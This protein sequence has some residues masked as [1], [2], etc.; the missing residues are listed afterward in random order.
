MRQTAAALEQLR[1]TAAGQQTAVARAE[2][3]LTQAQDTLAARQ[4][5]KASWDALLAEKDRIMADFAQWREADARAQ[6]Q[7]ELA[8]QHNQLLGQMKPLEI[9]ISRAQSGLEAERK[10]LL[11]RAAQ[12]VLAQEEREELT[13]QLGALETKQADLQEESLRLAALEEALSAARARLQQTLGERALREKEL[14]GLQAQARQMDKVAADKA[15]LQKSQEEAALLIHELEE[16]VEVIGAQRTHVAQLKAEREALGN[17]QPLL[18]AKMKELRKRLDELSAAGSDGVCPV[19]GQS[20]SHEHLEDALEN[21]RQ[22]GTAFGDLY[23]DNQKRLSALEVELPQV[24]KTMAQGERLEG[25]LQQ[26]QKVVTQTAARLEELARQEAAWSDGGLEQL[27]DAAAVLA[28]KSTLEAQTAEVEALTRAAANKQ[29]V[30][31]ALRAAQ[32]AHAEAKARLGEL[33]RLMRAWA[34]EGEARLTGVSD[35][36][37]SGAFAEDEKQQLVALQKR[38]DAVGYDH[39]THQAALAAREVLSAAPERQQTLQRAEAALESLQTTLV[40][41]SQQIT[42]QEA[43]LADQ[44]REQAENEAQIA[45]LAENSA[46]LPDLETEVFQLREEEIAATG[47]VGRAQQSVAVLNTLRLQRD[48]LQTEKEQLALRVRRLKVLETSCGRKGVQALLIEQALPEIEDRAN[49]LLERLT[50][51]DMRVRFDTQRQKKSGDAMLETLDIVIEDRSG[52]RPYENYSGG[53]Q[54][55]INFAIRLA[56]SQLLTHRTGARLQTLVIDEGFGS[57]DPLGRQRL[58][59]AINAVQDDFACILVITHIDELREAF[60]TR[61]E[62]QKEL[63]GSQISI[64]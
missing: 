8:N 30:Q 40:D 21:L 61:I 34:A 35:Q 64:Y 37:A 57:Q 60:P 10:G 2:R 23:R 42:Q 54:F 19:C 36:L 13:A 9:A 58:I 22:D 47:K 24:E 5:E 38:L 53:E 48:A 1:K 55:R 6:A 25:A 45:L 56:L 15:A 50:G 4:K 18:H 14:A 3:S 59:E 20:L 44:R 29:Q 26:Q 62:V 27:I 46:T 28:D 16:K 43:D 33:E 51:G 12:A 17:Q 11:E 63:N 49:D 7:Q 39:A 31:Q 41:L 52:Q 32:Q